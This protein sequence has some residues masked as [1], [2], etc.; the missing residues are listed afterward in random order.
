MESNPDHNNTF[1]IKEADC[2]MNSFHNK[3]IGSI[4]DKCGSR[5]AKR[6]Q[7]LEN[8]DQRYYKMIKDTLEMEKENTRKNYEFR[9][10][11]KRTKY[12]TQD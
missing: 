8:I 4:N 11:F 2:S 7:L 12:S 9:K 5:V 3:S 1:T 6:V 10:N